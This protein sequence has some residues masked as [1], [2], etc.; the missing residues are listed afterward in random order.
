MVSQAQILIPH[1]H[2]HMVL[3][4]TPLRPRLWHLDIV[5]IPRPIVKY[6]IT[7][8]KYKIMHIAFR[9]RE[10]HLVHTFAGIPMLF[11]RAIDV[12]RNTKK[13]LRRNM[14]LNCSSTRLKSS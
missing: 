13:A 11:V 14:T 1:L 10:F 12:T 4:H 2:R 8:R 5:G 6:G 3:H 9:F 7:K